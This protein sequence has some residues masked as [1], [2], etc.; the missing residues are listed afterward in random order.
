MRGAA[1]SYFNGSTVFVD[2]LYG[3]LDKRQ[4]RMYQVV[5]RGQQIGTIGNCHGVYAAH[6]HLEIRKN[7]K[8][9]MN[10]SAFAKDYSNYYSPKS[11]IAEH[12]S[13]S[14]RGETVSIPVDSFGATNPDEPRESG[15]EPPPNVAKNAPKVNIPT[16]MTPKANP[17][18]DRRKDL[19]EQLRLLAEENKKKAE[20]MKDEDMD[21]FWSKL[22]NKPGKK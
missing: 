11:F 15:T 13:L 14:G 10:R 12:R 9:G 3:H 16:R 22:K 2:S 18:E 1:S 19:N 21:G 20:S 8:I 5:K 7:L 6:L 4:A 17:E